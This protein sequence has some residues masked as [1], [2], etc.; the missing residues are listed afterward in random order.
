[1]RFVR[2]FDEQIVGASGS[3]YSRLILQ[4]SNRHADLIAE[5]IRDTLG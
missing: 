1:M 3:L 5:S 4:G 2:G